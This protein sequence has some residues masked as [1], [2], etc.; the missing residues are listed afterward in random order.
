M[1]LATRIL[2]A[3]C[4]VLLGTF[5]AAAESYCVAC[6]GPDAVYRCVIEGKPEGAAPDP[7]H[8]IQCIKVLAKQGG[9]TRCSVERFSTEGCTGAIK[10]IDPTAAPMPLAP[11]PSEAAAPGLEGPAK[12]AVPAGLP[13]APEPPPAVAAP[14]D[15]AAGAQPAGEPPRTVEELAKSTVQSTKKSLD[16]VTGTVKDTTQKAGD[17]IEGVGS[18]IGSAAKKS[19]RCVSSFFNDC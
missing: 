13:P 2:V 1:M 15:S 17:Q 14:A 10:V 7:R 4:T 18:A 11:P 5:P 3:G 6:F 16:T 12:A 8:Q 9:H 19:W